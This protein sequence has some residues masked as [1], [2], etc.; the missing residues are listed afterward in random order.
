MVCYT[1]INNIDGPSLHNHRADLPQPQQYLQQSEIP[2][3]RRGKGQGHVIHSQRVDD[4]GQRG[5]GQD[6]EP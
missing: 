2:V 3:S 6:P 5:I 4:G 1:P